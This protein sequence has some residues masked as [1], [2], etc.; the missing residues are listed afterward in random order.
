M[1]FIDPHT[2][3]LN[4]LAF[5][6]DFSK[7]IGVKNLDI[8]TNRIRAIISGAVHDG[9]YSVSTA[10]PFKKLAAFVA[11]F[12]AERPMLAP[13]PLEKFR[14]IENHQNAI[15]ALEIA[16]DSL[17]GA[18]IHRRDGEFT[19][20]NKI[21][22][23]EHSYIDIVEAISSVTPMSGKKLVAVLLEQMCYRRN[24]ECEYNLAS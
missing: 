21:E 2:D 8:D 20:R 10:S 14:N 18:K 9:D 22:L 13:L 12:V 5:I 3:L 16:I 1:I 19:L 11:Y 24:P 15:F 23:S 17:Y 6:N 7:T 4:V